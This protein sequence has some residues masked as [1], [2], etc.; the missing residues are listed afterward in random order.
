MAFLQQYGTVLVLAS[1]VAVIMLASK[2]VTRAD[3]EHAVS[4]LDAKF[5]LAI[6]KIDKAEDRIAKLEG[7][8]RH[9]PDRDS[10]HSINVSLEQMKGEL[11]ALGAQLQPVAKISDR[12][13]EFLL[14]QAKR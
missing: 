6:D 4:T 12:L 8:F 3:H 7:E 14:E 1:Q 10:V 5:T 11:K 13:Q 9:L 2:F